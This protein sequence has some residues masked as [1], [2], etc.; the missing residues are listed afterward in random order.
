MNTL[1]GRSAHWPAYRTAL[2]ANTVQSCSMLPGVEG[3]GVSS[4]SKA[5]GGVM[6]HW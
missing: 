3:A 4:V 1:Q 6:V 2:T 5:A